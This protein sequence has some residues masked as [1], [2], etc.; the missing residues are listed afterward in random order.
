M[1]CRL[2][3]DLMSPYLIG[4][5][6]DEDRSLVESHLESCGE[7]ASAFR[8]DGRTVAGLAFSVPQRNVPLRV[9]ERLFDRIEFEGRMS[10]TRYRSIAQPR[11]ILGVVRR[12]AAHSDKLAAPALVVLIVL[13]GVWLNNRLDETSLERPSGADLAN[14][15]EAQTSGPSR[16]IG[17]LHETLLMS[18]SPG[19]S[20][21]LLSGT[22][23]ESPARGMLMASR[24]TN[25]ALLLVVDL[26]PLPYNR[27]YQVWLIRDNRIYDAGWFT[28]DSTGY[29]QTVIIPMAPFWEFDAAG[30]TI[31]PIGGSVDPTGVNVL[32]GDL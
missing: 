21:N 2:A 32:S 14:V 28:V 22:Q 9:K 4:A 31:E 26:P 20:V 3:A 29:G 8:G 17:T 27:V 10:W 5:L 23:P 16:D 7:C 12:L 6:D 30:I 11:S 1:D 24:K 19:A 25:R 18:S 13:A 15:V